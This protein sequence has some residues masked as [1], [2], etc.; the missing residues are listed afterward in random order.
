MFL[1]TVCNFNVFIIIS[2]ICIGHGV[3]ITKKKVHTNNND[4]NNDKWTHIM[5][6]SELCC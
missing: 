6:E 2:G 1:L 4:V 5:N 3:A